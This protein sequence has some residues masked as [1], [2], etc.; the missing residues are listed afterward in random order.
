MLALLYY[1]V[2]FIILM[3]NIDRFYIT[4]LQIFLKKTAL[5]VSGRTVFQEKSL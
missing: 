4:F 2:N 3:N 1:K 5:R